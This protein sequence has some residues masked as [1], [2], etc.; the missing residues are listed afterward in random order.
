MAKQKKSTE[1]LPGDFVIFTD[2]S[3]NNLDKHHNG[4]WAFIAFDSRKVSNNAC[5]EVEDAFLVS[6]GGEK[7]TTN[8]RMELKAILEAVTEIPENS[9]CYIITDSEYC[10]RVLDHHEDRVFNANTDIIANFYNA[11]AMRGIKYNFHWIK[12]HSGYKFNEVADRLA[13][14]EYRKLNNKSNGTAFVN[15]IDIDK[16]LVKD[17]DNEQQ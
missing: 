6:S 10:I 2:G 15:D 9:R 11:V 13:Q 5:V 4:G 1:P 14:E 8:N 16:Y 12:G 3:C 17:T 7:R